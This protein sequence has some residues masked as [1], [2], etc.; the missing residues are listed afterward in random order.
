VSCTQRDESR[1]SRDRSGSS[2]TF[3]GAVVEVTGL[4]VDGERVGDVGCAARPLRLPDDIDRVRIPPLSCPSITV[5][6]FDQ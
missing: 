6:S 4:A 3:L 5:K 2:S 1:W